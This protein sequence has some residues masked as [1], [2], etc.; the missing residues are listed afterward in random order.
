MEKNKK[1]IAEQIY[2]TIDEKLE[3]LIK[4]NALKYL[5]KLKNKHWYIIALDGYVNVSKAM[6]GLLSAYS[7][8][9]AE[10]IRDKNL[11][12]TKTTIKKDNSKKYKKIINK[13]IRKKL[14]KINNEFEEELK[15]FYEEEIKKGVL[16]LAAEKAA[17]ELGIKYNFNKFNKFT[18]DYLKDKKINWAKQVARTTE[19]RVKELLVKGFEEGLG[20]YDIADTIQADTYFSYTRAEMVARTEVISSCNYADFAMWHF[21][22]GIYAKKWSAT[23]DDR[24]RLSHSI[25]DGQVKKIDEPFIVGGEKLMYP[26]DSSLGASAENIVNCRCTMF[27][28]TKEEYE[29]EKGKIF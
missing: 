7:K 19:D 3:K 28:L 27:H 12:E 21:D 6:L 2:K 16:L 23:G 5:K 8:K 11:F 14:E 13:D 25:A 17:K 9:Y 24:T 18:R 4:N 15:G 10:I 20:S 29:K 22:D 1:D 26:L